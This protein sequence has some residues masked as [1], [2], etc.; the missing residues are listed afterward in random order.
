[1]AAT[2]R[3]TLGN[4]A[5]TVTIGVALATGAFLGGGCEQTQETRILGANDLGMHCM[6][7]EFSV[8]SILPPFNLLQA[9]VV[10]RTGGSM[11]TLLDDGDVEVT[12]EQVADA[13]GS[14][15]STSL[16]GK[17]DFWD[18]AFDLF[19][20]TL[21]DGEGLL[22][23][24]MPADAPAPGPQPFHYDVAKQVHRAE[25]IP[26][27]PTDDAMNHNPYPLM[28]ITARDRSSGATLASLD[29]TVPVSQEVDCQTCHGTGEIAASDPGITWS[30]HPDPEI[31]TKQNVL[32][33]HDASEGTTLASQT[34]VLCAECHYSP[35]LDLDGTGPTGPQ[36]TVPTM[37]ATIHAFHG[38]TVDGGGQPIFPPGGTPEETC[39]KCHPGL[40]TQCARGAMN[41]GDMF[42]LDCHG[43]MLAVGGTHPLAHG[44]SLDGTNDG[45]PRRPWVD[46]PR[47]QSCHTGDALDHLEDP[48]TVPSPDGIRLR[49]AWRTGDPAASAI[50]ASNKRF[51]E[52]TATHFRNSKGHGGLLCT[53]CHGSPHAVWPNADPAA[54]DNVAATQLQGHTGTITECDTCHNNGSLRFSLGGP[55][56]MHVVDEADFVEEQHKE[57]YAQNPGSCRTCHGANLEGTVLARVASTRVFEVEDASVVLPK[58][59]EVHC[60]IC[61][62]PPEEH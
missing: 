39:F 50:L 7:R 45:N 59:M 38:A 54:N 20:A 55:H 37:S 9:D 51:A 22:G 43:D 47:C 41:T 58:G 27:T 52:N 19:G 56:G 36:L 4:A 5:R 25:G 13:T 2:T 49:Q 26:L 61:H 53:A 23:L 14:I 46:L 32:I 21:A 8:F 12:Y 1:M 28:R 31:Q 57:M 18:H 16:S 48:D 11:P 24:Y 44:G 40:I 42:C 60:T 17:T 33:L 6:D 62:G 34:P 30:T 29:I 35:A 10:Q 15:N 3:V